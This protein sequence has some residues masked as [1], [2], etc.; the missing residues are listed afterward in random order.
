MGHLYDSSN[1]KPPQEITPKLKYRAK[2]T[3][4]IKIYLQNYKSNNKEKLT[5]EIKKKNQIKM[6]GTMLANN[7]VF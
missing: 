2:R 1:Q 7:F 6:L 4:T 5:K 3:N